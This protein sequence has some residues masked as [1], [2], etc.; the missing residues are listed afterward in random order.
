MQRKAPKREQGLRMRVESTTSSSFG[1]LQR[2]IAP[3][4]FAK[5][6]PVPIRLHHPSRC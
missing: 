3:R 6:I 1:D 2:D 5:P 4:L